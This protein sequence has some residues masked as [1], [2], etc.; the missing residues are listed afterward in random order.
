MRLILDM[1]PDYFN[2]GLR[3]A[4]ALD[5]FPESRSM[6]VGYGPEGDDKQDKNFFVRRTK[7]G[8]SVK[9]F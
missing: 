8:V 6:V 4:R 9:R 1:A 3:A 2:L 5:K 7:T